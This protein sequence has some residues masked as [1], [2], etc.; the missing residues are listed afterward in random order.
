MYKNIIRFSEYSQLEWEDNLSDGFRHYRP[1]LEKESRSMIC[2]N[3]FHLNYQ[4]KKDNLICFHTHIP[5]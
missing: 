5:K 3:V 2:K 1:D 4:N